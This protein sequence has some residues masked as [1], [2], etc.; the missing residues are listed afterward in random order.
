MMD[1]N[2]YV[3]ARTKET[4]ADAIMTRG[5][6]AMPIQQPRR[7]NHDNNNKNLYCKVQFYSL[8]RDFSDALH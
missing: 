1:V 5:E 3:L 7:T 2:L 4:V 8:M 6:P